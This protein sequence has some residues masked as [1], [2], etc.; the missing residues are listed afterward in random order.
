MD[1]LGNKK[2][3]LSSMEAATVYKGQ[4]ARSGRAA[5]NKPL[6]MLVFRAKG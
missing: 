1:A 4:K 6:K 5:P 2:Q 3:T